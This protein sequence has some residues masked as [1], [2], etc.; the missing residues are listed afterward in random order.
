MGQGMMVDRAGS[1]GESCHERREITPRVAKDR[2]PLW[3]GIAWGVVRIAPGMVRTV[4]G[5]GRAWARE[6]WWIEPEVAG[7]GWE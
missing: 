4:A 7:I 1:G 3:R 5:S 2:R 6:W